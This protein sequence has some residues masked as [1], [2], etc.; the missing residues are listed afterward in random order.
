LGSPGRC[1]RVAGGRSCYLSSREFD[2]RLTLKVV[3]QCTRPHATK[4]NNALL[5]LKTCH[6]KM[7]LLGRSQRLRMRLRLSTCLFSLRRS[8]HL[9][10]RCL[11]QSENLEKASAPH[12]L[13]LRL[14]NIHSLTKTRRG[15]SHSGALRDG[16][17]RRARLQASAAYL[18]QREE[19]RAR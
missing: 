17:L 16:S 5:L 12:C 10:T 1:R 8:T 14:H 7:V 19:D 2:F 6:L 9:V 3:V 11:P 4:S 13:L 15:R 18:T